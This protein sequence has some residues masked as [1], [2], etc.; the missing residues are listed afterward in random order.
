M[1]RIGHEQR[2]I[3]ENMVNS[4]IL[5]VKYWKK[6][7]LILDIGTDRLNLVTGLVDGGLHQTQTFYAV[8]RR[9]S[10]G[11]NTI[12]KRYQDAGAAVCQ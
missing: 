2:K 5:K 3:T 12:Q 1:E 11:A 7:I 10:S 6:D 8:C 4:K 9:V